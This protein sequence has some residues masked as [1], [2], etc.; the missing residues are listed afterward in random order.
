MAIPSERV[1]LNRCVL[2]ANGNHQAPM[3]GGVDTLLLVWDATSGK[4]DVEG[5]RDVQR[6][7]NIQRTRDVRRTHRDDVDS[8]SVT[9]GSGL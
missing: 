1:A 5:R 7:R 2:A 6:K 4:R 9:S 8:A 3:V